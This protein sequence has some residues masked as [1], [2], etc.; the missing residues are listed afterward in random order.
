M[1]FVLGTST[2]PLQYNPGEETVV[3]FD[4][5]SGDTHLL[6]AFA[7]LILSTLGEEGASETELLSHITRQVDADAYENLEPHILTIL[8]QL[9]SLGLVAVTD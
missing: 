1:H 6:S 7:S 4:P 9:S 2:P 3:C 5:D 8:H